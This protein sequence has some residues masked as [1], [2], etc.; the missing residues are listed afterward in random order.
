MRQRNKLVQVSSLEQGGGCDTQ[1]DEKKLETLFDQNGMWHV[2][3]RPKDWS[4]PDTALED[5]HFW[6]VF[7]VCLDHLPPRHA[8]FFMMREIVELETNE[9]CE[10]EK[11]TISNLH[12]LLHRARLRLREC[13]ELNWFAGEGVNA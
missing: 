3:K 11:I 8:K 13:L 4:S 12:V 7:E 10:N 5:D 1:S 9:I 2:E 6:R